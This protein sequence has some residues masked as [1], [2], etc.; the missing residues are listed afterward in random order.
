MANERAACLSSEFLLRKI[1][2]DWF[3]QYKI[4]KYIS[5]HPQE[6]DIEDPYSISGDGLAITEK[7][8]ALMNK[9]RVETFGEKF[10]GRKLTVANVKLP[11][12]RLF[13]TDFDIVE[14]K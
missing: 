11:W 9:Y 10:H 2:E 4:I 1:T 3:H 5:E 6:F 12:N 8:A 7:I 13:E 14:V